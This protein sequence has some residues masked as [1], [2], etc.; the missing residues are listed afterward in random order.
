MLQ[1]CS[2]CPEL[3]WP[4][5]NVGASEKC[6]SSD[7][8]AGHP[9]GVLRL[10][11]RDLHLLAALAFKVVK[12]NFAVKFCDVRYL[13]HETF[14]HGLYVFIFKYNIRITKFIENSITE[15]CKLAC[16]CW[17]DLRSVGKSVQLSAAEICACEPML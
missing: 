5:R 8:N 3:V 4:Q 2:L 16:R 11:Y 12:Y 6:A 10:H 1:V 7:H 9:R 17:L 14:L 13:S 15:E